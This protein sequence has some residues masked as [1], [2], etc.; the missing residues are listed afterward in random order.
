MFIKRSAIATVTALSLGLAGVSA[1]QAMANS[2]HGHGQHGGHDG[3]AAPTGGAAS[4]STQAF[5]AANDRM[6]ED[7]MIAFSGDADVDFIRGMIPHHEGA[8]AM[9]EIVLQYGTDPEVRQLA[10][11]IISAQR[12]EIEWMRNWLAERGL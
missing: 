6:H 1:W 10:E 12:D 7:M 2:D 9:A 8:V 3:H 5:I 4:A 11:A